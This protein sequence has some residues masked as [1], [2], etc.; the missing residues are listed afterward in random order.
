MQCR[1]LKKLTRSFRLF[2]FSSPTSC[3]FCIRSL[4]ASTRQWYLVRILSMSGY[5][6]LYSDWTRFRNVWYCSSVQNTLPYQLQHT[7]CI[8]AH[9]YFEQ[10]HAEEK[11][12]ALQGCQ[13]VWTSH[14][15]SFLLLSLLD[16]FIRSTISPA[17][18]R[19]VFLQGCDEEVSRNAYNIINLPRIP[20]TFKN[21]LN[22]TRASC[23]SASFFRRFSSRCRKL[24]S[25]DEYYQSTTRFCR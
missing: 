5:S 19:L 6:L 1:T 3:C 21:L 25:L 20:S 22:T 13:A 12:R 15:F 9:A 16:F 24:S 7:N 14:D 4:C 2:S 23:S 10:L 18:L 17:T 8:Q 11:R